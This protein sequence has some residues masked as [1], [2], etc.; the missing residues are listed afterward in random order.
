MSDVQLIPKIR[1]D[2]CG[3]T[4]EKVKDGAINLSW[5]RPKSWGGLRVDPT[6]R[7]MYP[8]NIAYVDLCPR[9]LQAAHSAVERALKD[10][11]DESD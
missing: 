9:C 4:T 2:N 10:V 8:N 6:N 11:R 5:V 3:V 7:S 1:C